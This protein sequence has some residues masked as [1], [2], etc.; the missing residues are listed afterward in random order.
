M[1]CLIW[2]GLPPGYE[3]CYLQPLPTLVPYLV[4]SKSP[5]GLVIVLPGG[6]YTGKADYEGA[7]IAEW[8]NRNGISAA[9]LDYRVTPYHHPLPLLDVR[10]AIQFTRSHAKEWNIDSQHIGLLGFS[11]GGHLAATCGTHF[12]SY[13][14]VPADEISRLDFKPNAL[15][16][17]YPVISFGKFG[18]E[19][20]MLSLL[21]EN[22]PE[23]LRRDLSNELQVSALTPPSFIWQTVTDQAVPVEN[24]FLFAQALRNA[25][26][27]FELHL[28]PEGPHGMALS[29][30]DEQVGQWRSLCI[31]WLAGLG[32][33]G[34]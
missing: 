11:A 1:T 17:C 13:P 22:P 10:R 6:G 29:E 16:L 8:L 24:A 15:V 19:G 33:K 25:Q 31:T 9:V 27:P 18:H 21:G 3:P 28:F 30:N 26:V 20:S 23:E 4:S 32:F 12:A 2:H 5:T 7:P 14:D 34:K